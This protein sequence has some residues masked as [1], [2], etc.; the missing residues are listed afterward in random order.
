MKNLWEQMPKTTRLEV[1]LA[2]IACLLENAYEVL[3][4]A[5]EELEEEVEELEKEVSDGT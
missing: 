2:V 1:L 4:E 3:G 5:V